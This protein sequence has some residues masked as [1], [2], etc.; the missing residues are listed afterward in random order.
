MTDPAPP[1][2]DASARLEAAALISRI[3]AP[4]ALILLGVA[5]Y[6]LK[7]ETVMASGLVGA[8]LALLKG[9]G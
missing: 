9:Q 2:A 7:L 5:A 4:W 6:A 8:G 1:P 3:A